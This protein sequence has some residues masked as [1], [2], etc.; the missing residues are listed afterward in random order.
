MLIH[1]KCKFLS[2][3]VK[4][5]YAKQIVGIVEYANELPITIIIIVVLGVLLVGIVVGAILVY[6][7]VKA[8]NQL[9]IEEIMTEMHDLEQNTMRMNQEGQSTFFTVIA[10]T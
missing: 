10:C 1:I 4:V 7:K 6:K 9:K 3:Q 2:F 5:G 8:R